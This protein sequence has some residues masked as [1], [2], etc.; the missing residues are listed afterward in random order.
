MTTLS[1]ALPDLLKG[2]RICPQPHWWNQ[3]HNLIPNNCFTG[4]PD[5]APGAPL[6]LGSW[7]ETPPA[8]KKE[9]FIQHLQWAE[10]QGALPT[11]IEYLDSLK[12][13]EWFHG[14]F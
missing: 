4:D 7:F 3:C 10:N 11:V 5:I 2:T 9:R 6:I 14:E 8:E 12:E 1:E 13:K